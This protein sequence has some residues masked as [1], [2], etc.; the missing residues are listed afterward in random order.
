MR[1]DI[2]ER[3]RAGERLLLAATEVDL[4]LPEY[5]GSVRDCVIA[6]DACVPTGLPVFP[7]VR[8]VT[9]EGDMQCCARNTSGGLNSPR[10]NPTRGSRR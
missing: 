2:A 5:V 1:L 10:D 3:L 8:H 4:M 6:L 9:A 7:G